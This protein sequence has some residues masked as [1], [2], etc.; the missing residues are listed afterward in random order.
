MPQASGPVSVQGEERE[1]KGH[2]AKEFGSE[3]SWEMH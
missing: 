2:L 3:G 1:S